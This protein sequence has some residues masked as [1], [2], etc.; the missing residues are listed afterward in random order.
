LL[1][2]LLDHVEN[3]EWFCYYHQWAIGDVVVWDQRCLM[4]RGA[5]D[6]PTDETKFLMLLKIA[7]DRP[8]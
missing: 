2:E 6:A 5:G 4:H 3:E 1:N 8:V 7:G